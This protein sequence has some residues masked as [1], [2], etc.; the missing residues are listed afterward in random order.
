MRVQTESVMNMNDNAVEVGAAE[1]RWSAP[2][3]AYRKVNVDASWEGGSKL[4]GLGVVVRDSN[5]VCLGGSCK[6]RLVASAIEVEAHT[7]LSEV[8]LA[9]Q[10][11]ISHVVFESD[12]KELVQSVKGHIQRS[13]WTIFPILTAIPRACSGFSSYSWN[14]VHRGANKAADA[15]PSRARRSMCDEV[16]ESS[17]PSS[18]VFVLQADGLPAYF[19]SLSTVAA[20]VSP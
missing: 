3:H 20:L 8:Y 15:A 4:A 13:R 17:L 1:A 7:V 6:T 16:W 19:S 2:P 18:L 14:W 9:A 11:G 10:M 5:A 12:S